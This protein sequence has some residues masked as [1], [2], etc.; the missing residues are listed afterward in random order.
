M[1]SRLS[2]RII[3]ILAVLSALAVSNVSA[4]QDNALEIPSAVREAAAIV[5]VNRLRDALSYLTSDELKGRATLTQGLERAVTYVANQVTRWGLRPMGDASGY[6]QRYPIQR[7]VLD[8][9][10]SRIE[11]GGR[12][13]R[14]GDDFMVRY[15]PQS[16]D[17][18]TPVVYVG[19]GA[20]VRSRKIDPYAGVDYQHKILLMWGPAVP[21]GLT[22][23]ERSD[24][25]NFVSP[26]PSSEAPA[27]IFIPR[28]E[29]LGSLWKAV[30]HPSAEQPEADVRPAWSKPTSDAWIYAA[31]SLI[32]A[33]MAG[34]RLGADEL[35]G[36]S[37]AGD[38]PPS[39]ELAR[40]K[41]VRVKVVVKPAET[42]QPA[43]VLAMV[44]GRDPR[45][46]SEYI[47]IQAHL[48][49][50]G[51]GP[52]ADDNASGVAALLAIAEAL[53]RAP[54]PRRSLVLLW[55][56]GEERR[57]WGTEYFIEH[58]P[59]PLANIVANINMDMI[60]RTKAS[61]DV[62]PLNTELTG[63]NEVYVSG[64]K[65]LSS[66]LDALVESV[67]R[68]YLALNYNRRLDTWG[69]E[70]L[71]PRADHHWFLEKHIPVVFFFTGLHA[72]YHRASDTIDKID[73]P[74]LERIARTVF[75]TAWTLADATNRPRIDKPWPDRLKD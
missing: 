20:V 3:T 22:E 19:H 29:V 48:D 70:W 10:A 11:S 25:A 45:L 27:V 36:R 35:Y 39:F 38:P 12:T 64:P 62:D 8:T 2:R 9:A 75:V 43:N 23:A 33:L 42:F 6:L 52:A 28:F 69:S 31:P 40:D 47:T 68:H 60:G 74:K 13:F 1:T 49:G 26:P 73:V 53:A 51:A 71:Y 46:R 4:P 56:T 57:G 24:P 30:Q 18:E 65:V 59:I 72:D 63:S 58:S 34:E 32:Q 21:K 61:G 67:N 41:R 15:A 66:D 14:F 44:E 50:T 7:F 37:L 55:D 16:V 54:R 17:V 5:T